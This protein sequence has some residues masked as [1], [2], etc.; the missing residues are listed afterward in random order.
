MVYFTKSRGIFHLQ[1]K[2]CNTPCGKSFSP[3]SMS[4][5]F[6]SSH[7]HL[8]ASRTLWQRCSIWLTTTIYQPLVTPLMDFSAI[9]F[10]ASTKSTDE[11][12]AFFMWLVMVFY[13][14]D[15]CH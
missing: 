13:P 1:F 15:F 9:R 12:N 7:L 6:Y 3:Q 10:K 11:F 2:P 8:I 4:S 14:V 5:E